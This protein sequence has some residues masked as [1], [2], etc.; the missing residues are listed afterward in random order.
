MNADVIMTKSSQ[1]ELQITKDSNRVFCNFLFL[2]KAVG[3][4]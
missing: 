1:D 4:K 2:K 3:S